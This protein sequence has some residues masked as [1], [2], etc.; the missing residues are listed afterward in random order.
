MG[1]KWAARK[2]CVVSCAAPQFV[3]AQREAKVVGV[4]RTALAEGMMTVRTVDRTVGLIHQVQRV[5]GVECKRA[6][7]DFAREERKIQRPL[8]ESLVLLVV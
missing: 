3:T 7:R 6:G 2:R 4:Q 1:S 8:A 5:T